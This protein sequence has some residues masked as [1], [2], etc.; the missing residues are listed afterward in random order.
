MPRQ[1]ETLNGSRD[2]RQELSDYTH[3]PSAKRLKTIGLHLDATL[4]SQ[5]ESRK[6][7]RIVPTCETAVVDGFCVANAMDFREIADH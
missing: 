5:F 3:S 7:R 4:K 2:F 6:L 1:N